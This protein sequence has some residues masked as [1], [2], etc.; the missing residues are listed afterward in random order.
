MVLSVCGN[1]SCLLVTRR[2]AGSYHMLL[3]HVRAFNLFSYLSVFAFILITTLPITASIN[4]E[5]KCFKKK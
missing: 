5:G 4:S 3:A 1:V 2:Y